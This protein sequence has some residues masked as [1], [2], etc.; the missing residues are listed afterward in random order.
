MSG[1]RVDEI[2]AKLDVLSRQQADTHVELREFR[3]AQAVTCAGACKQRQD[4][5]DT[6]YGSGG[7]RGLSGGL[8]SVTDKVTIIWGG[9]AIAGASIVALIVDRLTKHQQ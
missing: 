7:S 4:L 3:A 6:V 2:L 8:Q 9:L 1:D 5:M